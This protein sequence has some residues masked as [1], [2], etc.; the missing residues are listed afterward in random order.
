MKRSCLLLASSSLAFTTACWSETLEVGELPLPPVE[1]LFVPKPSDPTS[2][3]AVQALCVD[4]NETITAL[5]ARI[6]EL[7]ASVA[8]DLALLR[9]LYQASPQIEG[10][11]TTYD[12]DVG[13]STMHLEVAQTTPDQIGIIGTLNGAEHLTG[14]ADGTFGFSGSFQGRGGAL[15]LK[16]D[17]GDI[18]STWEFA[19]GTL[20]IARVEGDVNVALSVDADKVTLA[21]NEDG[22][23]ESAEW[24]RATHAGRSVFF[25]TVSCWDAAETAADMCDVACAD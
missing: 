4:G 7:N 9:G 5:E 15:V 12:V 3:T 14:T 25:D 8:S 20:T 2:S 16:G 21:I 18:S 13:G 24:D 19:D 23:S 22:A 11:T 17:D 10:T 6:D 1:T